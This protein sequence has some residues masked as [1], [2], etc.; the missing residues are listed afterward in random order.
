MAIMEITVIP[1]G[2]ATTSVS[3]YVASCHQK[4]KEQDK[5][6]FQLTPMGTILEGKLEDIFEIAKA[7]HEVPFEKGAERVATI[8]KLD[9]RRDKES[10]MEKKIKSVVDKINL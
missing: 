1:L 2:T 8:M 6:K 7:L 5:V 10:T 4:L 9:D 3:Q